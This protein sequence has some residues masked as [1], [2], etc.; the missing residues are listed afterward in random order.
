MHAVSDLAFFSLLVQQRSIARAAQQMGITPPAVSKRLAALELRLGVRLLN[1]TTRRMSLT[2]EGEVYLAGSDH[3]LREIEG[4]EH[5]VTSGRVASRGLVKVDA[6]LGFG[7]SYIAPAISAFVRLYPEVQV[8][9]HLGDRPLN[10][11][12]QGFDIGIRVGNL[13]EQ[14]MVAV[15]IASN[16][17]FFC[18]S[19]A[20]IE[21]FSKPATPKDLQHHSCIVIRQFDDTYGAWQLRRGNRHET[22]KVGGALSTNDGQSAVQWALDG[23]GIL[24]RSDWELAPYLRSGALVQLLEEWQAPP[25]DIYAVYPER[26]HLPAKVRTFI[27]FLVKHFSKHR[28][29]GRSSD[30]HW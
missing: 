19:P 29:T 21:R 4:L 18:A 5:A 6:T 27:D 9:L 7:R 20:Y 12:D 22:V 10:L 23:Q 26:A 15:R 25:A 13:P 1:R 2:R 24:L 28:A 30:G 17:R 11:M 8:Q 3:I 16:R 14:R